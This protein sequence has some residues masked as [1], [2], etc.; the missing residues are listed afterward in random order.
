MRF[1]EE[2]YEGVETILEQA[3]RMEMRQAKLAQALRVVGNCIR[4]EGDKI[5]LDMQSDEV[6]TLKLGLQQLGYWKEE[7]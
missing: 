3:V 6:Q 4:V 7:Q 5:T 2:F 1:T